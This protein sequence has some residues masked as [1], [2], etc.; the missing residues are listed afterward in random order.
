MSNNEP[1]QTLQALAVAT[2]QSRQGKIMICG[3]GGSA[4]QAGHFAAELVGTFGDRTRRPLA[5]INLA[6]D[7]ALLTAI[8][9][10]HGYPQ[11]FIR[12]VRALGKP[13]DLLIGLSTSGRSVNVLNAIDWAAVNGL[14]T[15]M[16]G[17]NTIAGLPLPNTLLL[18][19]PM[20]TNVAGIQEWTLQQL[21]ALAGYIDG[22]LME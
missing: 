17:G 10:D 19:C 20:E 4:A 2:L 13:G 21:H 5:C 12:Q 15:A 14:Q 7:P 11:T 3:N 16:I 1:L 6:G 18:A 22:Y 8:A 9:N